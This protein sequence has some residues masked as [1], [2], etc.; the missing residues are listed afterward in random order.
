[1]MSTRHLVPTDRKCEEK[2]K[3]KMRGSFSLLLVAWDLVQ[4]Q[5]DKR[6][7]IYIF[8]GKNE[9]Y[10]IKIDETFANDLNSILH[11]L[12]RNDERRRE[13]H[14]KKKKSKKDDQKLQQERNNKAKKGH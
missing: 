7:E 14:A 4:L 9:A 10:L 5:K 1:M 2:K 6:F 13:T 11:I 8:K 3:K 12:L